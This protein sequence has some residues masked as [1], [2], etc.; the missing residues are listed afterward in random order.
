ML[1]KVPE[2]QAKLFSNLFSKEGKTLVSVNLAA[3]IWKKKKS[4]VNWYGYRNLDWM[5]I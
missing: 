4:I 3:T 2:G 1:S 5:I